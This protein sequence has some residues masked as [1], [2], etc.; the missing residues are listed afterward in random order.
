MLDAGPRSAGLGG[1]SAASRGSIVGTIGHLS[2]HRV[3][4]AAFDF[5]YIGCGGSGE[6][7][8]RLATALERGAGCDGVVLVTAGG[9]ALAQEALGAL[10]LKP[11][12]VAARDQ[13]AEARKPLLVVVSDPSCGGVASGIVAMADII[14]AE[15]EPGVDAPDAAA[16]ATGLVDQVVPRERLAGIIGCIL[17]ALEPPPRLT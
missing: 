1:D 7:T 11:T 3:V 6:S 17:D 16:T 13:L 14:L 8:E 12:V 9:G 2:G 10:L 15:P 5:R 4:C